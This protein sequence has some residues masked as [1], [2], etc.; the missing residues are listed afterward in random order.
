MRDCREEVGR[1]V[2]STKG[3][4]FEA[5]NNV[6]TTAAAGGGWGLWIEL[7]VSM[8]RGRR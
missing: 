1:D 2:G 5:R 6:L 4:N 8:S 3:F 7:D